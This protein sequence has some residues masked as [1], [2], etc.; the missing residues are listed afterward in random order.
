[1]KWVDYREKLGIGFND[2]DKCKMLSNMLTNYVE[3]CLG[4]CYDEGSHLNY[5]Q[6]LGEPYYDFNRPYQHL[7]KSLEQCRCITE[8]ISKFIALH[9]IYTPRY[10][11]YRMVSKKIF[12]TI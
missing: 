6:M 8:L 3:N 10:N 7:R 2:N 1:M 9:N 12:L 11:G 4:E 5:C